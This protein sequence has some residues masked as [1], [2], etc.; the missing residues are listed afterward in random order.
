MRDQWKRVLQVIAD[1]RAGKPARQALRDAHL[2]GPTVRQ[3]APSAFRKQR[4]GRYIVR[5]HDRLLRPLYLPDAAVPGGMREVT[6]RDSRQATVVSAYW[7]GVRRY[8]RTGE[9]SELLAFQ[10]QSITTGRRVV[11]LLTDRAALQKLA[12]A[13]VFSFETLYA[14]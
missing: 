10:G 3:W 11:P 4:N 1:Q 9:S 7:R 8:L 2:T 13:G 6:I 14:K 12:N 5:P